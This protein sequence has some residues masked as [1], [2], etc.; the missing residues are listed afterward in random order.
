MA[1]GFSQITCRPASKHARTCSKWAWLG[2]VT[3]T[4]CT[5][6][7]AQQV[8]ERRIGVTD[9]DLGGADRPTRRRGAED[10]VD[11]H[12][13]APQRLDMERADEPGTDHRRAGRGNCRHSASP[14][15]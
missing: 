14:V 3:C 9:A 7:S 5:R 13:E 6:S 10:T 12:P 8:V 1:S 4:T 2:E 15:S 11:R